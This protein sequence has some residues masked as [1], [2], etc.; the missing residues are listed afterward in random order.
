MS[1]DVKARGA[2]KFESLDDMAEA[3]EGLAGEDDAAAAEVRA[4]LSGGR[5]R[6]GRTVHLSLS[7]S[8]TADANLLFQGWLE[9]LAGA[10]ASGHVDTWQESFGED[11][12]VRLHAGG[13]EETVAGPFIAVHDPSSRAPRPRGRCPGPRPPRRAHPR[14]S[15]SWRRGS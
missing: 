6:K 8:L 13:S 7:C 9:D 10:A 12:F 1:T 3:D 2:L 5:V 14:G 15:G 4:V 11:S